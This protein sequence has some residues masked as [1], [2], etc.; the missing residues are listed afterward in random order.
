[1]QNVDLNTKFKYANCFA[2]EIHR[3]KIIR[4]HMHNSHFT[5]KSAPITGSAR[6]C[7]KAAGCSYYHQGFLPSYFISNPEL[8]RPGSICLICL[9]SVTEMFSPL[10]SLMNN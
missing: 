2:T 8:S 10:N 9:T 1:M 5:Q 6:N 3:D 4:T 7:Y